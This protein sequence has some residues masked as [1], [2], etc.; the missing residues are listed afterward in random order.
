M[1][2]RIPINW[3]LILSEALVSGNKEFIEYIRTLA[4]PGNLHVET[5]ILI[6]P[7]L[8]G[9]I[10]MFDYLRNLLP[11][12]EEPWQAYAEDAL[13]SGKR[14]MFD[15][16]RNLAPSNYE[17]N[18]IELAQAALRFGN[19]SLFNYIRSLSPQKYLWDW[20]VLLSGAII[21]GNRKLVDYIKA[22]TPQDY[23]PNWR[24]ISLRLGRYL[25]ERGSLL[26]YIRQIFPN[27]PFYIGQNEWGNLEIIPGNPPVEVPVNSVIGEI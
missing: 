17:W 5:D 15:H 27:S 10:A 13:V 9:N 25:E 2:N 7:L 16:V 3:T 20:S 26:G 4:P 18:W 22:L 1:L 14:T 12:Q 19:K 23:S 21:S 11:P 6:D 8:A 24:R